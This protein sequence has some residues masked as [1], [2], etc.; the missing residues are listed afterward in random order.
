MTNGKG[1]LPRPGTPP[2]QNQIRPGRA[3]LPADWAA[4][5]DD[6]I[7]ERLLLMGYNNKMID[8]E[9]GRYNE[10][11]ATLEKAPPDVKPE[12][13]PKSGFLDEIARAVKGGE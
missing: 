9:L 8:Y 1:L 5:T 13:T 4:L 7:R 11:K 2:L 3:E 12:P 10:F 6:E